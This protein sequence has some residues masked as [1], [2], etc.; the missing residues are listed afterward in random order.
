MKT[1][2]WILFALLVVIA[3]AVVALMLLPRPA[4]P[5]RLASDERSR[6]R[7][8]SALIEKSDIRELPAEFI[9]EDSSRIACSVMRDERGEILTAATVLYDVHQLGSGQRMHVFVFDPAGR[10]LFHSPDS[11]AVLDDFRPHRIGF[12]D[13]T[14]DGTVEKIVAFNLYEVGRTADSVQGLG[15]AFQVWRLSGTSPSLLLEVHYCGYD[16]ATGKFIDPEL[17]WPTAPGNPPIV[18]V[19]TGVP[20]I[21]L[22]AFSEEPL[23]VFSWSARDSTY[24]CRTAASDSWKVVF[25]NAQ[26]PGAADSKD[27]VPEP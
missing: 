18:H 11:N 19:G 15:N 10:C 2:V 25:P 21:G 8:L 7:V 3:L 22:R 20:D 14:G 4:T 6:A 12:C 9:I 24:I 27:A 23:A 26:P 1:T 17:L 16:S 13:L 5:Q